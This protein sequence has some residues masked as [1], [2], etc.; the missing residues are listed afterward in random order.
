MGPWCVPPIPCLPTP[1][2]PYLPTPPIPCWAMLLPICLRRRY[3]M[4]CDSLHLIS[5]C[6]TALCCTESW[7]H[8]TGSREAAAGNGEAEVDTPRKIKYARNQS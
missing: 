8:V 7:G 1:P 5:R 3:P 6:E 4:G 2:I